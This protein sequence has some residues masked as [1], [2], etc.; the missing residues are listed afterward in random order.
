MRSRESGPVPV[1][2]GCLY[3]FVARDSELT[4][5]KTGVYPSNA[6]SDIEDAI[7][8]MVDEYWF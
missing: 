4:S 7:V 8:S 1:G 2:V 3:R 6:L 5:P